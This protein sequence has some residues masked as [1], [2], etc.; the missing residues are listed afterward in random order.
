MKKT[1]CF[2][3]VAMVLCTAVYGQK[4]GAKLVDK[5]DN[6]SYKTVIIGTQLWM[7]ENLNYKADGSICYGNK[8]ANCTKYGRLYNWQTAMNGAP[9][10]ET[11]PSGVQGVCPAGWHLPSEKEW[12]AMVNIVYQDK[13]DITGD[14]QAEYYAR[15][16]TG[17]MLKS[18]TGWEKADRNSLGFIPGVG[19]N[20]S[21]FTALPGGVCYAD[22]TC[23][24]IGKSG[25][26]RSSSQ[27]YT[28][29][30][31]YEEDAFKLDDNV[32]TELLS[33]RCVSDIEQSLGPQ[34][35]ITYDLNGGTGETPAPKK[36]VVG[37][38]TILDGGYSVNKS[39]YMFD[40]WNTNSSGTGTN[41]GGNADYKP[42]SNIT[43]YAKWVR[44][45]VKF[46]AGGG[47]GKVPA[48]ITVNSDA[49]DI[50]LPDKGEL[51]KEGHDFDGW[52]FGLNVYKA[53]SSITPL[54]PNST[55]TARWVKAKPVVKTFVDS[56]DNKTYKSIAIGDQTWMTENLN[57]NAAGSVCYDNKDENCAKY[58]RLYDW[59]TA[60]N[61]AASSGKSPSRVQGVCP[62]GWHLP[63]DGE[64]SILEREIGGDKTA[65]KKLKSKSGW[66]KGNG[67][68]EVEFSALP[69]GARDA[70][71]KFVKIDTD[72][73]W[74]SA[75]EIDADNGWKRGISN[76]DKLWR[77]KSN[78]KKTIL[79]SVRCV[80]D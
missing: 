79:Y 26:W 48:A 14:E 57:Y 21:G 12:Q 61:G 69:G 39:G 50:I 7:A 45:S 68:D 66:K 65:G 19:N 11:S 80:Q 33:V 20:K 75:T 72:G 9:G 44:P 51:T 37:K 34:Y 67:T 5:R 8:D 15:D 49:G 73:N 40:G 63:S 31:V 28:W 18:K 16:A 55:A 56:R 32:E 78:A 30:L 36:V 70:E 77:D 42:K 38:E 3:L 6:K 24:E 64:W 17:Q 62:A 29:R 74:W 60:M 53:G 4:A 25:E 23:E 52:I 2:L 35:T 1:K 13:V 27:K 54:M 47:S 43:L 71:G 22:N 58:G 59:P 41:Y 46:D 76:A 10:S